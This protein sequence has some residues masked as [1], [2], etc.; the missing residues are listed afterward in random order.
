MSNWSTDVGLIVHFRCF[1]L[2]IDAVVTFN[3]K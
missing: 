3:R 1:Y 2:N